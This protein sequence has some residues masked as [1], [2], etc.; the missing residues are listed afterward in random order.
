MMRRHPQNAAARPAGHGE[1]GEV[2]AG[3]A[4]A[5]LVVTDP[6]PLR[7]DWNSR[8][9]RSLSAWSSHWQSRK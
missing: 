2:G 7:E 5:H 6:R 8:E 1:V 4:L 3:D 9:R